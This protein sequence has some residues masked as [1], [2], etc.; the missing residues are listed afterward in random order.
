MIPIAKDVALLPLLGTMVNAYLVGDVL[1]DAGTRHSARTLQRLLHGHPLSAHALTHAH[2]DHQ[3]SSHTI[4]TARQVP[5]WA[6]AIEA[7]AMEA[8]TLRHVMPRNALVCAE[9]LVLTGPAHPVQRHLRAGDDVHGFEVLEMPG[10]APGHLCFWRAQDRLLIAGD[11]LVNVR[12]PTP[13]PG[14]GEPPAVFTLDP[15]RNREA[16]RRLAALDPLTVLFGHGPPLRNPDA[17]HALIARFPS[18][19]A[20]TSRLPMDL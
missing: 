17:L 19:G 7:A 9:D 3:G 14:L 12:M 15:E 6:S 11:V 16:I 20:Q 13:L 2:P 5:L 18:P 8:G 10:H 1:I 4:C